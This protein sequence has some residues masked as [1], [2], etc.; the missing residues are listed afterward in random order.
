M[1]LAYHFAGTLVIPLADGMR[2][3]VRHKFKIY[4]ITYPRRWLRRKATERTLVSK[5]LVHTVEGQEL[6]VLIQVERGSLLFR[7]PRCF[8]EPWTADTN[9]FP[10]D[11][12]YPR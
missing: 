6:L 1:P 10:E 4:S 12:S 8:E 11:M 7:R 9:K 2:A 3:S 5:L